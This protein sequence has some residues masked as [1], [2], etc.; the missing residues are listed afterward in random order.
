MYIS[1]DLPTI[2]KHIKYW[3]IRCNKFRKQQGLYS[4]VFIF[5]IKIY[6]QYLVEMKILIFVLILF[7]NWYLMIV[8]WEFMQIWY[9]NSKKLINWKI[10]FTE[11]T[12]LQKQSMLNIKWFMIALLWWKM[13][14]NK[15]KKKKLYCNKILIKQLIMSLLLMDIILKT[16]GLVKKNQLCTRRWDKET[17]AKIWL[18]PI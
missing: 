8:W 9:V 14:R 15:L 18:K 6:Q 10:S 2:R 3:Q 11:S 17:I 13:R 16:Q 4:G 5:Q 1:W 12:E 7:N